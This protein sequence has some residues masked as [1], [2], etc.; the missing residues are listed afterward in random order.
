MRFERNVIALLT[1]A[2]LAACGGGDAGANQMAS[3]DQG[4]AADPAPAATPSSSMEQQGP[5]PEGVTAQMVTAGKQI[6]TGQGI[7]Y[8][9]HGPDGTGTQ[10]APDLTDSEWLHFD[11]KPSLDQVVQLIET[12]VPNPISHP[13]PMPPKGGS[14]I[15][16]EQ[17]RD[18]AA[19]VLTLSPTP[20]SN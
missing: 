2:A 1:A 5:L 18:V 15:S 11:S 12:G 14:S 20:S 4:A 9:C 17:V 16:D 13:A 3:G 6:F 19:Y 10:L 7:C 8:T